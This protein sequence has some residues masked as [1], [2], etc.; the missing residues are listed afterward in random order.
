LESRALGI[1]ILTTG[2]IIGLI[3]YPSFNFLSNNYSIY[4][5][6]DA[7]AAAKSGSDGSSNSGSNRDSASST[8]NGGGEKSSPPDKKSD[9]SSSSPPSPPTAVPDNSNPTTDGD[10]KDIKNNNNNKDTSTTTSTCPDGSKPTADGKCKTQSQPRPDDGCLFNPSL[11]KCKSIDEQCPK[12][13]FLNDDDNCV[14]DKKCPPGFEHHAQDETGA[15]YPVKKPLS[16]PPGFH[17]QNGACTRNIVK[18][19]TTVETV[20]KNVISNN[21]FTAQ[22]QGKQPTYLL[23]LDTAQLCQLA[24]DTQCVAKQNQFNTLNLIT[25]LDSTGKSWTI[26]GQVENIAAQSKTQRNVGVT[27]Y[28]YDSKGNNVGGSY[29]GGINPGVLKS[30]QSGAFNFKVSTSAMKGIPSFLRLE[31]QSTGS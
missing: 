31:Y 6:Q 28:F 20:T 23:L 5:Y 8:A 24:G 19:V 1:L 13:F 15:C 11:S 2:A 7:A 27:A 18:K 12:G 21:I 29:Q 16:C 17:L 4:H 22:S 25:K 14:P 10:K 9:S 3:S 26:T 30:L